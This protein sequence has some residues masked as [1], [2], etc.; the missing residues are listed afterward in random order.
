MNV[1]LQSHDQRF[2]VVHSEPWMAE[3]LAEIQEASFPDLAPQEKIRPEHYRSHIDIFPEGQHAVIEVS[4][5]RVVA[6]STDLR[7]R[8]DFAHFAHKYL[9]AVGG[10]YLTTHDPKGDWLY[11]ADIGVH[12]DYR[13]LGLSTLLYNARHRLVRD[14]G[15]KGHVAGAMPKGYGPLKEQMPIEVYVHKVVRG[16]LTDPVLSVQLKRGYAVWGIIPDYL[17]DASCANY[18]VFIV[19]RNPEVA[20]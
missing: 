14:L 20:W 8:V 19:W 13:G 17:E 16:E 5:G 10:N 1:I 3:A 6:C 12:P 15:L 2:A 11:G 18:G 7:T 4:T 9:E